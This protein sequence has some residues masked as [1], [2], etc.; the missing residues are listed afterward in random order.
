MK[1]L[2]R[3]IPLKYKNYIELTPHVFSRLDSAEERHA[4]LKYLIDA[5]TS[6]GFV[7]GPE[8]LAFGNKLGIIGKPKGKPATEPIIAYTG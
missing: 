4:A 8:W 1:F 7:S 5:Q 2:L 6:D 3:F